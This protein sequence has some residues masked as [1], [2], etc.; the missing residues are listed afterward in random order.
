[1]KTIAKIANN[2]DIVPGLAHSKP[3]HKSTSNALFVVKL[4]ILLQTALKNKLISKNNKPI[5]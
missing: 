1:M 5:R 2:K 4:A 3:N